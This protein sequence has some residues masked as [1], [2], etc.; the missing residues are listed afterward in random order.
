MCQLNFPPRRP[1]KDALSPRGLLHHS[2]AIPTQQ[3]LP[4]LA[5]SGHVNTLLDQA[6]WQS[7]DPDE[8]PYL[9]TLGD[10]IQ[11]LNVEAWRNLGRHLLEAGEEGLGAADGLAVVVVL[12]HVWG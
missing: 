12:L 8:N 9:L 10:G 1:S 11:D 5:P 4:V 7:R 3:Q 6:V 2:L